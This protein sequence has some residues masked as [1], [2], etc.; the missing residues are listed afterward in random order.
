MGS[1]DSK[2]CI[3]RRKLL[4]STCSF[5]GAAAL[6]SVG[7]GLKAFAAGGAM[8]RK[9]EEGLPQVGDVLVFTDANRKGQEV[10]PQDVI[11]DAAPILVQPKDPATGTVRDSENSQI[12]LFRTSADKLSSLL[13]EDAAEGVLAYS[14]LC[15]HLGCVL[16][17]WDKEKQLLVCPCHE[18]SF[19]VLQKGKVVS[20]PAPRSLPILPLKFENNKLMVA[21]DFSGWVGAKND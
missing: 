6:V 18:A 9:K 11:M 14:A 20:G 8:P 12:L 15:T 5:M 1:V 7:G 17:S 3:T 4:K 10:S 21:D 2:H 16:N 13:K 19:D